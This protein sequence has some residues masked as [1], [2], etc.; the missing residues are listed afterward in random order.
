MVAKKRIILEKINE[1]EILCQQEA[2]LSERRKLLLK[3]VL[4]DVG[5]IPV[6]YKWFV[7]MC[8]C[9]A[10]KRCDIMESRRQFIIIIIYLYSPQKLTGGKMKKGIRDVI[11]DTLN[12]STPTLISNN[13]KDLLFMYKTYIPF[14]NSTDWLCE[15]ILNRLKE[16]K[17][18]RV[19]G[20]L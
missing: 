2:E 20:N 4:H 16:A 6:I 14:Q 17:Y 7:E 10:Y 9:E 15:Q 5:L 12:L 3:P 13:S 19:E 8:K 18:M 1:I 11:Q